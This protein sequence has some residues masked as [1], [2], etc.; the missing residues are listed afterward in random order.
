MLTLKQDITS[1]GPLMVKLYHTL[2]VN[3]IKKLMIPQI[4][5]H[6]LIELLEYIHTH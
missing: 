5:L 4:N 3:I 2:K 1:L 6:S